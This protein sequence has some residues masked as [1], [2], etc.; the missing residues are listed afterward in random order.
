MLCP[1]LGAAA[2]VPPVEAGST[3]QGKRGGCSCMV[4]KWF[5]MIVE[6]EREDEKCNSK[7]RREEEVVGVNMVSSSVK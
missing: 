1:G 7:L 3:K 4:F 6:K 5:E 2:V